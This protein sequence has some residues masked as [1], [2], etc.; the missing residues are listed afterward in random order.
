MTAPSPNDR[1][2][3]AVQLVRIID[4]DTVVLD[5]DL[6]CKMWLKD[7]HCRLSGINTPELHGEER[8]EGYRSLAGLQYLIDGKE[9][10]IRMS[11]DKRTL[12]DKKGKFGRWLVELWVDGRSVNDQLVDGGY[13]EIYEG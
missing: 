11:K 12:K 9:I 1:Y 6:G 4:G 10:L 3:Y 2:T 5:I 8:E 13:A 7:E